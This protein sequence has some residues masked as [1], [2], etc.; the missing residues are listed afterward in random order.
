MITDKNCQFASPGLIC[1]V[2]KILLVLLVFSSYV[3]VAQ[4]D[5]FTL[6]QYNLLNYGNSANLPAYKDPR[7][8]AIINFVQPDVFGVNEVLDDSALITHLTD[9]V[10]GN[11]W[12]H[13]TYSN[14]NGE[15]QVNMLFWKKSLFTLSKE[16]IVCSILRD[17]VAYRLRYNDTITVPHDTTYVTF[18]VAHLK[19]G[20]SGSEDSTRAVETR[21]VA[22]W[23]H[24]AGQGF[25]VVQ[26]DLNVYNSTDESYQDLLN[27][28]VSGVVLMDPINRPGDW[29]DDS[30]FADIHTQATRLTTI[31]DGGAYGGL[32][33]RFDQILVSPYLMEDTALCHYLTGTY[34]AVGQDGLHFNNSVNALPV[35]NK[36][37]AAVIQALYEMSD[38]LPVAAR[39]SVEARI[40]SSTGIDVFTPGLFHISNP[41]GQ[42]IIISCDASVAGQAF[43]LDLIDAGGRIVMHADFFAGAVNRFNM[44]ALPGGVYS[45]RISGHGQKVARGRLVKE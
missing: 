4:K 1:V 29:H 9:S 7:L 38:H 40:P 33:D 35:N 41:V 36:A 10:L 3:S 12:A 14:T 34:R 28:P 45:Y 32:D 25:Y 22:Q 18:I 17:I 44:N 30:T 8:E 11:G 6:L 43:T 5:S 15:T 24:D 19:A 16:D 13:A 2:R 23:L 27:D 31:G 42:E 37:P 21:I 39:F 20:N 26:G